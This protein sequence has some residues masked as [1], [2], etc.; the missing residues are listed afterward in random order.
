MTGRPFELEDPLTP[1]LTPLEK[2]VMDSL[3]AGK[4][5]ILAALRAQLQAAAILKREFS[6]VGFFTTF[7]LP[8]PYPPLPSVSKN[9]EIGDVTAEIPGLEGGAGFILFV[10]EGGLDFLEGY[11]FGTEEWPKEI[12]KFKLSFGNDPDRKQMMGY[13]EK[14]LNG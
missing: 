9:M 2:A 4:H 3:L 12:K 7:K 10:R 5:P 13:L 11:T 1:S 14:K 6:G 8:D